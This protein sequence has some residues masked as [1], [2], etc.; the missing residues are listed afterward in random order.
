MKTGFYSL[1]SKH[2]KIDAQLRDEQARRWP[3]LVRIQELKKLKLAIKDRLHRFSL[4][5]HAQMA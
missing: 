3:D 4:G 2:Q 1:L 5:R